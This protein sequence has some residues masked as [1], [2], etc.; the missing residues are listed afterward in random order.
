MGRL[1]SK[2]NYLSVNEGIIK[3][4][5]KDFIKTN[6]LEAKVLNGSPLFDIKGELVGLI[7]VGS[8]GKVK[9][10]SVKKLRVFLGL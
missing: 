5:E 10:I 1:L 9:V 6:M 4:F 3:S 2:T 8:Q 7:S